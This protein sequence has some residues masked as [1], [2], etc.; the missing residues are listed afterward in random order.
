MRSAHAATAPGDRAWGHRCRQQSCQSYLILYSHAHVHAAIDIRSDTVRRQPETATSMMETMTDEYVDYMADSGS[1][2]DQIVAGFHAIDE[3]VNAM[4]EQRLNDP[5]SLGD[6]LIK[7]FIPT[8][9][10]SGCR[11][12]VPGIVEPRYVAHRQGGCRRGRAA[13]TADERAVRGRVGGVRRHPDHTRRSRFQ[14]VRQSQTPSARLSR[15]ARGTS[16]PAS[17]T[18]P[19]LIPFLP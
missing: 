5:D 18:T 7:Y 6:K 11:Q 15:P 1:S 9:G 16:T 12:I 4:R 3:R 19:R 8:A 10:R 17:S 14:G 13:G 2:A